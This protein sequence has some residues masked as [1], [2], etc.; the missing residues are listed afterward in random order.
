MSTYE[1]RLEKRLRWNVE[2]LFRAAGILEL[3]YLEKR[4]VDTYILK[5][6]EVHIIMTGKKSVTDMKQREQV[7]S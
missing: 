4:V 6:C 7:T 3:K 2:Q 5:L 1:I